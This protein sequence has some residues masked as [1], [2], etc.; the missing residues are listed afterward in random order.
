MGVKS[1]EEKI[2]QV[3][4]H[5]VMIVLSALAVIPFWLLIASSF[6]EESVAVKFGY[7]FLPSV[8]SL[9]AYQYI[10][11]QWSQVGR[12][13]GVTIIVSTIGTTAMILMTAM[14]SYGLIQKN[15]RGVNVI[16]ILVLITMLFNGGIVPSYYVYNNF[17][18]VK[19]TLFGLLIPNLLM[20][21]FTVIL[22][23]NYLQQN[24]PSELLEAAE[25]DGAGQFKVFFK[26]VFP[27]STP[28][29]ATVGLMGG[30]AYWNDWTNGLYYINESKL[31]S[32]QQL[33]NEMNNNIQFMAN[34]ATNLGGSSLVDLPSTTIRMAIAVVAIIP[35]M[36]I[37]PF[38]QK[39]FAKGITMG[40]VK[41]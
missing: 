33:L 34:N 26:I 21:G 14:F 31:Y 12:A 6:T 5:I 22:V 17:L 1:K 10:L 35:I 32:I 9:E 39:Y 23:K 36:C 3:I 8:L 40:A 13:Y 11:N 19:N 2:M 28:I 30:V 38:F 27:L 29:L 20:N 16:F 18:H 7:K 15:V 4:A 41:G 24:I 37:Y 25:I